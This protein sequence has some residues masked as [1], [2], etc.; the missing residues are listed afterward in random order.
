MRVTHHEGCPR[1]IAKGR[2]RHRDNLG[3]YPDASAHCFSCGYHR[4]PKTYV[5]KVQHASENK[6]VLPDDF[7]REIPAEGWR[8]LLKYGLPY[9]YW[10][11]FTGYSEATDRLVFLVGQ[12]TRFSTGRY[13]GGTGRE[14]VH[15]VLENL[16]SG[17][18]AVGRFG[19]ATQGDAH[20]SY[21]RE[22]TKWKIWGNKTSYIEVLGKEKDGPVVLVEDLISAHKVA[23]VATAI[24]LFGTRVSDQVLHL[25]IGLKR[26]VVLWLD[27]D[28]YT[29][30]APKLNR[31]QTF[32]GA[33]VRYVKTEKDPKEYS[34]EEIKEILNVLKK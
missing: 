3:V 17:S 30:L 19:L 21:R 16:E 27:A 14:R 26:P 5:R 13:L 32:L 15:G 25:L 33:P 8:W 9:S 24:P 31:L 23:Q 6:A 20:E 12:P 2:D 22:P 4:F 28:Q 11:P 10:A 29:L 34:L 18:A 1:C 7:T